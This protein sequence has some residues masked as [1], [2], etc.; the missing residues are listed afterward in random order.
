MGRCR[1]WQLPFPTTSQPRGIDEINTHGVAILGTSL[2]CLPS[3]FAPCIRWGDRLVE[4]PASHSLSPSGAKYGL[5]GAAASQ[6]DRIP[7]CR[8]RD[9]RPC[10]A[11][12]L[13]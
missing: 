7:G 13:V 1:E 4:L 6:R 2:P 10:Q 11:F 3:F 8:A 5:G 9:G 12:S